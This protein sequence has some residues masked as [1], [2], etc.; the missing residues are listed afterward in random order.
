[1]TG[2]SKW[3]SIQGDYKKLRILKI[4]DMIQIELAKFG[5]NM[6]NKKLPKPLRYAESKRWQEDP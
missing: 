3:Q 2:K 6:T 4:E 5:C 1:M